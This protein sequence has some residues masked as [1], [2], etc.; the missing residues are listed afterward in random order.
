MSRRGAVDPSEE[1]PE[2]SNKEVVKD[3]DGNKAQKGFLK[4]MLEDQ[5]NQNETKEYGTNK[6]GEQ[7]QLVDVE[8]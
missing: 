3:L 4:D 2:K 1:L 6:D 8:K 7:I 5:N